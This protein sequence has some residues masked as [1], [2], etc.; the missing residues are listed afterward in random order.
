[1]AVDLL[2]S[3]SPPLAAALLRF[4]WYR[5][6]DIAVP[7]CVALALPWALS[8]WEAAGLPTVRVLWGIAVLIPLIALGFVFVEHQLDFRPGGIVQSNPP[9]RTNPR[10]LTAR[11]QAWQDVCE[12]IAGHTQP[13]DRF[14]TPRNQQ[15]FKWYAQ[16]AEVV[17]WKD[18]PQ[19]PASISQWWLLL[20]DIY[21][22][23]VVEGGL[24]AWSDEQLQAIADEQQV[25]YIV[26]DRAQGTRRLG[27]ERVYPESPAATGWFEVYRVGPAGP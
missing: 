21:P 25:R 17:C 26:L 2:T 16:R 5:L 11:Y 27:F 12:W 19:D 18:I 3:S 4:Y 15:T 13:Q 23:A 20:Q 9:G 14:L 1:M 8:R 24:A 6:A 10:Q 7:L 22:P